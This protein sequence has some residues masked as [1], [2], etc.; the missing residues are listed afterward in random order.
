MT[1]HREGLRGDQDNNLLAAGAVLALLRGMT[2]Q[3]LTA[4]TIV[5]D[6]EGNLTNQIDIGLSFMRSPYRITVE[7][8]TDGEE[9]EAMQ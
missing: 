9:E 6:T 7:R 5:T 2:G 4:V 8:V 3:P 1:A